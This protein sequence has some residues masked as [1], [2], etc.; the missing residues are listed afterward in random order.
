MIADSL[1][2]SFHAGIKFLERTSRDPEDRP[3]NLET[4]GNRAGAVKAAWE[5]STYVADSIEGF[6]GDEFRHDADTNLL[7]VRKDTGI[8]TCMDPSTARVTARQA[9]RAAGVDPQTGE[10]LE[11]LTAAPCDDHDDLLRVLP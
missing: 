5:R 4:P 8:V 1:D 3:G 10:P 2:A 9:V 7:L 6:T 11:G